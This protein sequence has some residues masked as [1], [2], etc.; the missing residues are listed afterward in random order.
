M[1]RIAYKT[2]A[3]PKH[4]WGQN[5]Y[6]NKIIMMTIPLSF[7][8]KKLMKLKKIMIKCFFFFNKKNRGPSE[9][10]LSCFCCRYSVFFR[11]FVDFLFISTRNCQFKLIFNTISK[12]DSDNLAN[13]I[14]MMMMFIFLHGFA[15]TNKFDFWKRYL[16]R[17]GAAFKN[18]INHIHT[19]VSHCSP[20]MRRA[21]FM[22][23]GMMVTR[24]AWMAHKLTSSNR[25]ARYA[26]LASCIAWIAALWKRKSGL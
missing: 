15:Q 5:I 26:S 4:G 12:I 21:N 19:V 23:V 17:F 16:R 18:S 2:K 11:I 24:L 7:R 6:T 13:H 3:G 1:K 9:G 20:R 8:P 22:S 25:M 14:H 10:L